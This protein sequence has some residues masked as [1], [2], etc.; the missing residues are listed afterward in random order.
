MKKA[1]SRQFNPKECRWCKNIL[2]PI[3]PS[4]LFCSDDCKDLSY[5]NS[6]FK[7]KYQITFAEVK[8][9]L[10]MQ[11]NKC[12]VC[13]TEGFKMHPNSWSKLNVDHDHKTGKVRE[14]L[15]HNCNRA[16]GLL[17]E[18]VEIIQS[19]LDYLKQYKEN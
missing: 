13:K 5:T 8:S 7:N 1:F 3:A 6:Y 11:E 10:E 18:N 17:Q 4:H 16:L 9:L 14:L 12:A 2:Q 15:C 19:A